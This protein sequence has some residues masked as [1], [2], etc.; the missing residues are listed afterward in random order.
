MGRKHYDSQINFYLGKGSAIQGEMR[1]SGQA[2][3]D[4]EFKGRINGQGTLL[5]GPDA[6]VEATISATTVII[7]GWV[8]GDVTAGERIELKKPGQLKGDVSA[9]LVVMEEGVL[10]QGHCHMALSDGDERTSKIKLLS[11]GPA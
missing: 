1:F 9:P 7:S 5:V 2:R 8:V 10:F 6:A 4:G 11:S 3:L